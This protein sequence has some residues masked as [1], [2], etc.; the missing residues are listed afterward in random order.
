MDSHPGRTT[1][2][3]PPGPV[4]HFTRHRPDHVAPD[5]LSDDE[6]ALAVDSLTRKLHS[7]QRMLAGAALMRVALYVI[8]VLGGV[9]LLALGPAPIVEYFQKSRELVT[10]WDVF[11]W[12]FAIIGATA[13]AGAL[14]AQAA[15]RRRRR[16]AGW[17]HRVD[18]LARRLDEAREVQRQRSA[19]P[20]AP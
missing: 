19:G 14:V 20:P 10:T 12:W 4:P 9:A 11:A 16:V 8:I 5:L 6:L 13:F 15:R 3:G 1:V 2:A 7:A 18:D 17:R